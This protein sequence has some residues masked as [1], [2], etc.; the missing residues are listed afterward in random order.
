MLWLSSLNVYKLMYYGNM[1]TLGRLKYGCRYNGP[2]FGHV[3]NFEEIHLEA[4]HPILKST[5]SGNSLP[6]QI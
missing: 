1:L 3:R 5:L 2:I 4:V 6:K